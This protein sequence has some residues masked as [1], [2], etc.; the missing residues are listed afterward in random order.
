MR[1]LL[2]CAQRIIPALV[3]LGLLALPGTAP[4]K[5]QQLQPFVEMLTP[6]TGPVTGGNDVVI[7]A[8]P[9]NLEIVEVRFGTKTATIKGVV[10]R[11][12]LSHDVTVTVPAGDA[13]GVVQVTVR[14][15]AGWSIPPA[16]GEA[17]YTYTAVQ[18]QN[19]N[20][21]T[22]ANTNNQGA[23]A[24]NPLNDPQVRALVAAQ[25]SALRRVTSS[26][27]D[28]VH[29]RM[30]MLH[31]DDV[32]D[33]VNN[34]M[35]AGSPIDLVPT[36]RF[37]EDPLMRNSVMGIGHQA[38]NRAAEMPRMKPAEQT[39]PQPLQEAPYKLWVSC[40]FFFGNA[41]GNTT[42][43]ASKMKHVLSGI[44]AGF[45]TDVMPGLKG[46]FAVNIADDTN[47]LGLDGGRISNRNIGGSLYG[48]WRIASGFHVDSAL[49]Y[50]YLSITSRRIDTAGANAYTG[51]RSGHGFNGSV[52]LS[53]DYKYDGMKV[54]AY[55]RMD[56]TYATLASYTETGGVDAM[57]YKSASVNGQSAALGLRG[58]YPLEQE[59]GVLVPFGRAEYRRLFSGAL[60]QTMNYTDAPGT[61]Y[62]L[63]NA[64]FDRDV[65]MGSIGL[66][67]RSSK[68]LSA[69]MEYL[70]TGGVG[71]LHGQGMRGSL[72]V[73]F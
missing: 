63:T 58:E 2:E 69:R 65:L 70:V 17:D 21:N 14:T 12:P 59:W 13:P 15:T 53:Y 68:D 44:A 56:A 40:N 1:L 52:A 54:A 27:I 36:A 29:R 72:R 41:H 60:N 25:A 37:Y 18:T 23:G 7:Q 46:G 49:G 22:N 5:A 50:G 45:D 30:E 57:T 51:D 4:A 8:D 11:N 19:N 6:K 24:R 38:I 26:N 31:E 61:S 67:A 20:T 10:R 9:Q 32:P 47:D 39:K 16:T 34:L 55:S 35:V 48:S 43:G 71:G 62:Q 73:S 64:G 33:V 3:A 42:S 66:E 28:S